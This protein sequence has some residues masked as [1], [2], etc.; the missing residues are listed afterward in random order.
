MD[1]NK[2]KILI[3]EDEE[4]IRDMYKMKL[5]QDGFEVVAASNG[6]DGLEFVKNEKFDLILL[7]I[8]MPQIDGFAVLKELKSGNI[9]NSAPV[10]ML[11]NLSTEDDRNKGEKMGAVGYLVKSSM[12]PTQMSKEILKFL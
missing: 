5:R 8:I 12:T 10:V 9:K 6:M 1:N 3:I 4:M 2:K 7:D 11:T